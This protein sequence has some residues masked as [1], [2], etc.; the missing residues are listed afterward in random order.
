LK[1]NFKN[2]INNV[3]N[4]GGNL[5]LRC[6][7]CGNDV[8]KD[9]F[10]CIYCTA[11]LKTEQIENIKIF[12]RVTNEKWTNPIK[13]WQRL[14]MVI[15]NPS[16]AFWDITHYREKVRSFKILWLIALSFGVLGI[17]MYSHFSVTLYPLTAFVEYLVIFLEFSLFGFIVYTLFIFLITKLYVRGANYS[18]GL[19]E[20]LKMRYGEGKK[21]DDDDEEIESEDKTMAM[22]QAEGGYI[23]ELPDYLT[24]TKSKKG[25]ILRY[26]YAPLI[27]GILISALI[28]F[29]IGPRNMVISPSNPQIPPFF[30]S[31]V[32]ILYWV[33]TII[34][35]GWVPIPISIALRDIANASTLRVYISS[36]VVSVIICWLLFFINPNFIP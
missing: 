26:A 8:N 31:V 21:D 22:Q 7:S 25:A 33:Q 19:S 13:G 9:D 3:R 16:R 34:L 24:G 29:I 17:S 1:F 15:T 4:K 10:V 27:I 14:L 28:V 20:Q 18:I 36:V 23:D 6:P 32:S 12:R 2:R 30:S 5:K 11:R 35:I